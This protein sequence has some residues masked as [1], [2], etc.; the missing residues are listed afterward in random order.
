MVSASVQVIYQSVE[1][2]ISDI[3]HFTQN[4][5]ELPHIT[6]GPIPITVMCVTIGM[7]CIDISYFYRDYFIVCKATLSFLCF[8]ISNP[9][10]SAL[11]HDHLNDVFSNIVAL[12][13]GIVGKKDYLFFLISFYT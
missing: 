8:Q 9:T 10:M 1:S 4:S 7:F 6:M 3:H 11:A 2:L 13:C 5:T 12:V